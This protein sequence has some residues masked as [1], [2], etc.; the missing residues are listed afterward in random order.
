M[1]KLSEKEFHKLI[2]KHITKIDFVKV[3]LNDDSAIFGFLVKSSSQFLMIEETN[4]FSMSGIKIVPYE[5]VK[6]I[7]HNKFD[8]MSKK[9]FEEE[10]LIKLNSKI[11]HRTFL[12]DFES[13]F[14]SIM[15][16]GFHCIIESKK[17]KKDLFSIG[18]IIEITEKSV[19]IKN[20]DACG[21]IFKKPD[22]IS[23]KN[24]E[25]INFNDNY[26]KIFRKYLK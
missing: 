26:S 23:F 9:I 16:Q 5:R 14:K 15:K 3:I 22:Q 11:I 21:K 18:E 12:K 19:I 2:Q 24:I 4:D 1:K 20:Y 8:K 13:L 10:A 25:I 17:K 6:S 7:R